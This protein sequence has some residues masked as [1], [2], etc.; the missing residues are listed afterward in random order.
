DY[1]TRTRTITLVPPPMLTKLVRDEYRPAYLF[2]RPPLGPPP[3][4]GPEALKG[5]K[6]RVPDLG[7][8]LA[9]PV[10]QFIV[11]YGTD[12]D[13][14]GQVDKEMTG[15]VLRPRSRKGEPSGAPVVLKLTDD[16]LGFL[17][18][19]DALTVEQDFD[20]EFTDTDNV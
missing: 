2:H 11:P 17:H 3:V 4:G 5:L 20:L 14:T 9:W 8:S 7:V 19:F 12:V 18:R 15:A 6:Q 13:L 16:R 10:S 1:A